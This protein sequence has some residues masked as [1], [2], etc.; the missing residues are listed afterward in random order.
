MRVVFLKERAD[1]S[2]ISG[3]ADRRAWGS[4]LEANTLFE[5]QKFENNF[6][7]SVEC[8]RTHVFDHL[9]DFGPYLCSFL[10]IFRRCGGV[11]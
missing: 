10:A 7:I 11:G 3:P 1:S 8:F 6:L 2:L 4:N 9:L 5:V